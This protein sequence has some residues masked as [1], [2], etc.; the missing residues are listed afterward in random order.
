ML[1]IT[2]DEMHKPTR[3][4][5]KKGITFNDDEEVINPEDVD[6]SVGRFRNLIQTTV[7]PSK[8]CIII[9]YDYYKKWKVCNYK[10]Y[11]FY[12]RECVWKE[13]S[14]HCWKITIL[15]NICNLRLPLL[16]SITIYLPNNLHHP[17]CQ[18]IHSLQLSRHSR[19]GSVSHYPIRR[20]RWRWLQIKYKQKCSM[21][22]SICR[23]RR[24][25][26]RWSPR[27]RSTPK[28]HGLGKNQYQRFLYNRKN[29]GS[30]TQ[31]LFYHQ[32]SERAI[33]LTY[34][35]CS[36]GVVHIHYGFSYDLFWQVCCIFDD[37]NSLSCIANHVKILQKD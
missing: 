25:R 28:R 35:N 1:G 6:P 5:K 21:Y 10:M 22:R 31:L 34:R 11:F 36:Y 30:Y 23:I 17:R 27:R 24:N 32:F 37:N 12:R 18:W 26:V 14:Y 16:N 33:S 8:V 20:P 4:R 19:H 29:Y 7:V 2:D 15:W 9:S 13:V 3:K